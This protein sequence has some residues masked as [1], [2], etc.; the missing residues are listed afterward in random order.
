MELAKEWFLWGESDL[1]IYGIILIVFAA[2][3]SRTENKVK[4]SKKHYH[5]PHYICL[6]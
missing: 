3:F 1:F 6:V 4:K 2:I 5:L